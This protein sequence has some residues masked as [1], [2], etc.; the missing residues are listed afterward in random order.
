MKKGVLTLLIIAI[1]LIIIYLIVVAVRVPE[2]EIVPGDFNN[3]T[4]C[5]AAGFYWW[6]DA[7]HAEPEPEPEPEPEI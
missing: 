4:D 2:L 3:Q 6:N 7:C 5:E 1:V